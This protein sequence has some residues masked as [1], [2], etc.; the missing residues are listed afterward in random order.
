MGADKKLF[1]AIFVIIFVV[2]VLGINFAQMDRDAR[3]QA[4]WDDW[5]SIREPLML[6]VSEKQVDFKPF[7]SVIV[8][9]QIRSIDVDGYSNVIMG[10]QNGNHN[11]TLYYLNSDGEI[12]WQKNISKII[13]FVD[14]SDDGQYI[15]VQSY[16]LTD[17]RARIYHDNLIQLFDNQGTELWKFP[18]RDNV[19]TLDELDY[20][21]YGVR[22]DDS[23]NSL[24]IH[25]NKIRQLDNFGN[26]IWNNTVVGQSHAL[27]ISEN[28]KIIAVSS[29]DVFDGMDYDWG[30]SIFSS[31][32]I[33]LWQ[34]S[35]T[36]YNFSGNAVAVSPSGN[37]VVIGL[38]A[39]GDEGTI[40]IFDMNG[41][42]K[43][44]ETTDSVV[45]G[46]HFSPDEKNLL[47]S[48]NN[49]LRF[50]DLDGNLLWI[51][52][53][54]YYP[55]FSTE[56]IASTTPVD[57][58]YVLKIMNYKGELLSEFQIKSP[59]RDVEITSDSSMVIVGTKGSSD[60]GPGTLYYFK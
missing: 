54:M 15:T 20:S 59:V 51:K 50:Y 11:G 17:G 8:S 52:D 5:T 6:S 55:S 26:L 7:T 56:Y 27:D 35:G 43:W 40:Q 24:I 16:E 38:A 31:D 39:Q 12:I 49:G 3:H 48:T 30:L 36:G 60:I 28:G 22:T 37:D 19:I 23:A 33:M 29:R 2:I 14:L 45:L 53:K 21:S 44:T 18:Q 13:G 42:L 41:S 10:T 58:Y 57:G 34:K 46:V 32:G 47:V 25:E 1:F 4:S 9:G